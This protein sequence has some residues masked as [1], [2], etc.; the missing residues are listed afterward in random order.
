MRPLPRL[1]PFAVLGGLILTLATAPNIPAQQSLPQ[2]PPPSQ[3]ALQPG[4]R[5]PGPT[6]PRG[7]GGARPR[8]GSR[9]VRQH[10]QRTRPHRSSRSNRPSRSR[11]CRRTR[12]PRATTC[13]GSR[14]TGTGTRRPT[15]TSG[16]A[17]SGATPPGRVWVP[18]SW[19]EVPRRLAVGRRVLAGTGTHQQPKSQPEIQYLPD[20]PAVA[21][22]RPDRRRS[23]A[24]RASTFPGSWVW[25]GRYVWRPGVWIELPAGLGVGAGPLSLDA[26]RLRVRGRLLGLPRWRRAACCSRRS[27]STRRSTPARRSSTRRCTW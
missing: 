27:S 20:P 5:R 22:G 24:R 11:N 23:R 1:V 26:P 3:V 18:G 14:A 7:R 21:R 19:R 17:G 2:L 15:S 16:S 13:S 10:R 8:A 9:G 6:V 25:R 4:G 12:S